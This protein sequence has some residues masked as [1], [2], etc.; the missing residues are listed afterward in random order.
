[1]RKAGRRIAHAQVDDALRALTDHIGQIGATVLIEDVVVE[2]VLAD[3]LLARIVEPVEHVVQGKL[4]A[5]GGCLRNWPSQG[6]CS[7]RTRSPC[8]H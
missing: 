2:D 6:R 4:Q 5:Q 3:G 8:R 7:S 1:M